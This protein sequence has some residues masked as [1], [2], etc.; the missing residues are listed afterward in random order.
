MKSLLQIQR[1]SAGFSSQKVLHRVSMQLPRRGIV[2]LMGPGGVG[3][4]TLLRTLSRW[5]EPLPNFWSR[6]GIK[7]HDG[8]DLL[9]EISA[10]EC[11]RILPLL[12]QKARLYTATILDNVIAEIRGEGALGRQK[13]EELAHRALAPLGLWKRFAPVLDQPVLSLSLAEQR[14]LSITRLMAAGAVCLLA[15]EPLRD[16]DDAGAHELRDLLLLVAQEQSVLMVGHNQRVARET[17]DRIVLMVAGRIIEEA[18]ASKFFGDPQ[19]DMARDYIRLGNCWFPEGTEPDDHLSDTQV[20]ETH[21]PDPSLN[22]HRPGGFHWILV[23]RLGGMQRPGLLQDESQDLEALR[24]LGCQTLV[25]LTQKPFNVDK[26]QRAGGI[27]GLHFPIK[28][29]GV[30]ELEA[31]EN[32][33]AQISSW[34][35]AGWVTILHCKAGLGR[36]GTML[37][38]ILIYRGENSVRAIGTVRG[39]N[40]LYIQSLEQL[41]FLSEFAQY[42]TDKQGLNAS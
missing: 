18:E 11:H 8:R 3:K 30:P 15:D 9:H 5:N 2:G 39:I 10:E 41:E 31:A 37:A 13:K 19:T 32:L 35:D 17:C 38:S 36:T 28:D 34:I 25:S 33:S 29:M 4:S 21:L 12:A 7:L 23:N 42:L 20:E 24:R 26:L 1:L 22:F 27:R 14:M 16:M 40:P 6:G